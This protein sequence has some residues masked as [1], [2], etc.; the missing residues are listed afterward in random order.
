MGEGALSKLLAGKVCDDLVSPRCRR[1]LRVHLRRPEKSHVFLPTSVVDAP[2][3]SHICGDVALLIWTVLR[4]ACCSQKGSSFT[5]ILSWVTTTRCALTFLFSCRKW[6]IQVFAPLK[7]SIWNLLCPTRRTCPCVLCWTS[8]GLVML[9]R[10]SNILGARIRM[11]RMRSTPLLVMFRVHFI[12]WAFPNGSGLICLR[13]LS[14]RAFGMTGKIVQVFRVF[15]EQKMFPAPLR[16]I[17]R[18]SRWGCQLS[19]IVDHPSLSDRTTLYVFA[20]TS[21]TIMDRCFDRECDSFRRAGLRVHEVTPAVLS[22]ET[23]GMRIILSHGVADIQ[24]SVIFSSLIGVARLDASPSCLGKGRATHCWSSLIWS[25]RL[26]KSAVPCGLG[27][28]IRCEAL[29][30]MWNSV[31]L[32]SLKCEHRAYAGPLPFVKEDWTNCWCL[33]VYCSGASQNGWS[34]STRMAPVSLVERHG[35]VLEHSRFRGPAS[36]ER[37]RKHAFQQL[38]FANERLEMSFLRWNMKRSQISPKCVPSCRRLAS[39]RLWSFRVG[40]GHVVARNAVRASS[41]A[42]CLRKTSERAKTFPARQSVL[43]RGRMRSFMCV[44]SSVMYTESHT[45]P[46]VVCFF[47]WVAV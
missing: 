24:T 44:P 12:T 26:A 34:F 46:T 29:D 23:F 7:K 32:V 10:V 42:I 25:Y 14:A 33:E 19:L 30:V 2:S 35:R 15:A 27:V 38:G 8:D 16:R 28:K 11:Q 41:S 20:G 4:S 43:T 40:C 47:R 6:V 1:P 17:A 39:C 22:A 37:A 36:S 13:P 31:G 45:V 3:L 5:T 18:I 21:P 9:S